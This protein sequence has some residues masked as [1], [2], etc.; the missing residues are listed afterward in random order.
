MRLTAALV[1]VL[2]LAAIASGCGSGGDE[3]LTKAEFI[4]QADAICK[5]ANNRIR[6]EYEAFVK[7]NVGQNGVSRAQGTEVGENILLPNVQSQAEE[8]RELE[9][10]EVDEDQIAAMLDAFEAGVRKGREE[11]K[12]LFSADYPLDEA[13]AMA[14]K[15]GLKVCGLA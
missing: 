4:E 6:K 1:G 10:P 3:R 5:Q 15:Y 12:S 14:H 7:E 8:V 13:N 2:A 11:P 9:P